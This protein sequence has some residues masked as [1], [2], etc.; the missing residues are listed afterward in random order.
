ML[1]SGK[2]KIN[3]EIDSIM[4]NNTWV[5][6][7]LLPRCKPLGCKWIFK[8]KM[9]VYGTIENF[10]ARQVIEGFKQKLKIGYFYTY[11]HVARIN[12]IR[13]LIALT[14][15]HILIIHQI[16]VKT[17]FL[18]C[19]LD[20]EVLKKFNYFDCT[21]KSTHMDTSEKLK[22]NNGKVV[23]QLEYSR[24][25]GCVMYAMTCIMDGVAF[26]VGKLS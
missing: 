9:K 18:N 12:T 7:N 17:T 23:S 20:E 6:A 22:P 11:A 3:D 26:E 24:V 10:K 5:V 2:K 25:I 19:E 14:S 13:L 15:I 4:G 1:L 16:D 21:L 8:R